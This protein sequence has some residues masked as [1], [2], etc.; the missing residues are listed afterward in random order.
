MRLLSENGS[1]TAD[2][3]MNALESVSKHNWH[4]GETTEWSAVF[5]QTT[6]E[7]VYCHRENYGKKYTFKING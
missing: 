4:D 7:A 5:D 2:E 6:G 1:F 3:V